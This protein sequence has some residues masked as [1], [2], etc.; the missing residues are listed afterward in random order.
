MEIYVNG[1]P[2]LKATEFDVK[3]V[4]VHDG[5][6]LSKNISGSITVEMPEEMQRQWQMHLHQK[7]HGTPKRVYIPGPF[8]FD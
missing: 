8:G 2:I 1:S 7:K 5:M 6:E 3:G 4:T